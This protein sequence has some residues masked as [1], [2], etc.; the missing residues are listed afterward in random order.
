MFLITRTH[1]HTPWNTL[2]KLKRI[3]IVQLELY[4]LLW[5]D[6]ED[7][8]L[9]EKIQ[10]RIMSLVGPPCVNKKEICQ[11]VITHFFIFKK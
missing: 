2:H 9:T 6:L 8:L 3:R 10:I 1:I 11:W 7:I 5:K 4:T